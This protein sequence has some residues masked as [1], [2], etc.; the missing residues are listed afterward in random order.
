VKNFLVV[1]DSSYLRTSIKRIL[2]DEGF[3]VT[4]ASNGEDAMRLVKET[5]FDL[6]ILDLL[7]PRLGGEHVLRALQEDS[8]TAKIPVIVVSSPPQS[9]EE[10]LKQDGAVAYIGKSKLELVND[11]ANF[12]RLVN[13]ALRSRQKSSS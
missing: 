3:T 2:T 8:A 12:V 4:S 13:A 6:I 11:G 10:K 7:L 1:E 9:N 5:T